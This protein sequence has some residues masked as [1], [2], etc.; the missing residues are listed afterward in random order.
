MDIGSKIWNILDKL[1]KRNE[2]STE[3]RVIGKWIDG[4]PLY[5][6][7]LSA[8]LPSTT[9]SSVAD[10][11]S[12]HIGSLVQIDSVTTTGA[13]LPN[14]YKDVNNNGYSLYVNG[15][16]LLAQ[17]TSAVYGRSINVILEY[18]KTTD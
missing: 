8:T 6:K 15:T 5:R 11:T 14:N 3:E 9:G 12:L 18:T 16:S 7:V 13:I 1:T 10:L 17:L 2:Y 4:K